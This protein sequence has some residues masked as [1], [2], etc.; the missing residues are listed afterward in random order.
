MFKRT[1]GA[2]LFVLGGFVTWYVVALLKTLGGMS[3]M[4]AVPVSGRRYPASVVLWLLFGYF[5][6]SAVTAFATDNRRRLR[7]LCGCAH[8]LVL[9]AFCIFCAEM[10]G[11]SSHNLASAVPRVFI[12]FAGFFLPWALVWAWLLTDT[13]QG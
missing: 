5:F 8:A 9:A 3:G 2:S 4:S 12:T 13:R 10:Y 6:V 7:V 1:V 11:G